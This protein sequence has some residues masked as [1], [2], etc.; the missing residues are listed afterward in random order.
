M[1]ANTTAN[2]TEVVAGVSSSMVTDQA[3]MIVWERDMEQEQQ[4]DIIMEDH[5]GL[6]SLL[7]TNSID[8][9]LFEPLYEIYL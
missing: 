3:I 2:P 9:C 6:L 4:E 5:L 1:S 7:S 8:M